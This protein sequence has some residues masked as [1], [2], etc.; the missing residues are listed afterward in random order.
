V[1]QRADREV[2]P[3]RSHKDRKRWCRGKPGVEHV[4]ERRE[5]VH[6]FGEH[7]VC[8][9]IPTWGGWV[10]GHPRSELSTTT[11]FC[12]EADVCVNCGKQFWIERSA[13]K[14]FGSNDKDGLTFA[15][16]R[17]QRGS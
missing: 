1:K 2:A 8:R 10:R 17:S 12:T 13:C 3:H 9:T 5:G 7:K 15:K 6:G 16:W 11:V 14:L 4:I